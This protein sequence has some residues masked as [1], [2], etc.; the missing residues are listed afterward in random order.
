MYA[1]QTHFINQQGSYL[2]LQKICALPYPNPPLLPKTRQVYSLRFHTD[3]DDR[4][5]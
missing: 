4:Q 1:Q 2:N 5:S 3:G